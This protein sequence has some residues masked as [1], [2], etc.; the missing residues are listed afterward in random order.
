[1]RSEVGGKAADTA[2][3]AAGMKML[4]DGGRDGNNGNSQDGGKGRGGC[5]IM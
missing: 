4:Q 5:E 3:A 2:A 1:M